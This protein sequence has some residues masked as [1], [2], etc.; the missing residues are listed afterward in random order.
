MPGFPSLQLLVKSSGEDYWICTY[1]VKYARHSTKIGNLTTFS[2][3]VKFGYSV[4]K[5]FEYIRFIT[6]FVLYCTQCTLYT[7]P[8]QDWDCLR[9]NL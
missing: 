9:S 2:Y 4:E 7:F 6:K 1:I 5:V 3:I 8:I